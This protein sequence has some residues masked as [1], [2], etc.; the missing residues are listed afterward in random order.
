MRLSVVCCD[1][2]HATF[3]S[4]GTINQPHPWAYYL[5]RNFVLLSLSSLPRSRL[6]CYSQ[7]VITLWMRNWRIFLVSA[8]AGAGAH[9]Y[10]LA[11]KRRSTGLIQLD[12]PRRDKRQGCINPIIQWIKL[13]GTRT[14]RFLLSSSA[15]LSS[16]WLKWYTKMAEVYGF[17]TAEWRTRTSNNIL[18]T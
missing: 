14:Q 10:F 3:S 1:V 17:D 12:V 5:G 16:P 7:Q 15:L 4:L 8:L 9:P 6:V 18:K 11:G 13:V 2:G